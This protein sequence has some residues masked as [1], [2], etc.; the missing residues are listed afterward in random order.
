LVA[1]ALEH[2]A[3]GLAVAF[4]R[5]LEMIG[6][7]A[8]AS[9]FNAAVLAVLA[10]AISRRK[11]AGL[12]GVIVLVEL[13]AAIQGL[14]VGI[15]HLSGADV[16]RLVPLSMSA[17]LTVEVSVVLQTVGGFACLAA[18]GV[19][20]VARGAFPA[21]VPRRAFAAA[22]GVGVAAIVL[23]TGIGLALLSLAGDSGPPPGWPRVWWA[24]NIALGGAPVEVLT[25]HPLPYLPSRWIVL[26]VSAV[27]GL[28]VVAALAVFTRTAGRAI[29]P[30]TAAE[31]LALRRLILAPNSAPLGSPAD[32]FASARSAPSVCSPDSGPPVSSADASTLAQPSRQP[33][34]AHHDSLAYVATRRDKSVVFA[35]EGRAAV[36][37][38]LVGGVLLASGDPVGDQAHWPA[39]IVQW[40]ALA[41]SAGWTP[42]VIGVTPA[43]ALAY[44]RFGFKALPMGDE[45]VIVTSQFAPAQDVRSAARRVRRAGYTVKV[46]RL[47]SIPPAEAR[48]LVALADR[49]RRGGP[50]RGFSMAL[51]RVGDPT[52]ARMVVVTA[53]DAGPHP[54]GLLT[55]TP[56][57]AAGLSLDTMRRDPAARAGVTELMI[58]ELVAAA[59]DL[60]VREVSLNFAVLHR[61]LDEANQVGASPLRRLSGLAVRFASRWWQMEGLA[62]AN[63]KY[64]PDWRPR[65]F[66]YDRGAILAE[67]VLAAG[68][69]EGV[70]LPSLFGN[71]VM[72]QR[73]R[74]VFRP[75]E[76]QPFVSAVHDDES[77]LTALHS[78][79]PRPT[80]AM[81]RRQAALARLRAAGLDPYPVRVNRHTSIG[82]VR[83]KFDGLAAGSEADV[84]VAVAGRVRAIRC[85]GGLLF[86]DLTDDGA[87]VQ[88]LLA[89]D[90]LPDSP[91][92]A[93][94]RL[95]RNHIRPGDIVAVRGR[96]IATRTGE[97]T[98]AARSWQ[99]ASKSLRPMVSSK[100][101]AAESR[102]SL[103]P[104]PA[105]P[106]SPPTLLRVRATV[107]ATIRAVLC[108]QG[109]MEVE[110]PI[111]QRVHGG[112]AAR[113]FRTHA[114]AQGA[115]LCLRIAPELSLKRLVV[116]G[117]ERIF[118]LGRSFRNEG[119]D[120]THNPEFTSL[121]VYAAYSDYLEMMDLAKSIVRTCADAVGQG[122]PL[123]FGRDGTVVDL[124]GTWPVIQVHEA[125]SRACGLPVSLDMG[126]VRAR[127]V[128][129]AAG[130]AWEE[131]MSVGEIVERCYDRLVEPA[132]IAPTFYIGF[133][134]ESSP[135]ARPHRADPRYAERWDLVAFGMELG[136]AYSELADPVVQR[137][138]LIAQ[139]WRAAGGEAEAMEVDEDF[140]AAL[141]SGLPPTGGLGLGV[142]RIVMMLTGVDIGETLALPRPGRH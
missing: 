39:A 132:T 123:A 116:A 47:G 88:V 53:H 128:A 93:T 51:G 13:P 28:G 117:N 78:A 58:A 120:A 41:R 20:I 30:L 14:A 130:V 19:L 103:S 4:A 1:G 38:R 31:E 45:A 140:L 24:A 12:V 114:R 122:R 26:T 118:E 101:P 23:S 112:A 9:V 29:H 138:R 124:G 77:R 54:R 6:L 48:E 7:P 86:A 139:S 5:V 70:L 127:E 65:L 73:E 42:A 35:P 69:A 21:R 108:Q 76:V 137:K 33:R 32:A 80:V 94:Y 43:G 55:L 95:F 68:R 44:E 109:F 66:A 16:R 75:G 27:S 37:F 40:L 67:V 87:R 91:G 119:M 61:V 125:V 10:G 2:V 36:A 56:W 59:R 15:G 64:R 85:H 50:E 141:E 97:L 110:T 57:G 100:G 8:H 63:A 49:W 126:V 89:R 135:L 96:V 60:G 79:P 62:R 142:D 17:G 111:L 105:F 82:D 107:L 133:P 18:I 134:S 74:R 81:R 92:Y 129:E 102:P 90:A 83:M 104:C 52:D 131:P 99:L 22:L 115:N 113:P 25:G 11:R 136:T 3:P 72:G 46:R 71:R 106:M 84:D 34:P 121:E 98:I